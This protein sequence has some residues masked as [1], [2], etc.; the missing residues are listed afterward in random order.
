MIPGLERAE[1]LRCGVMHKNAFIQAPRLLDNHYSM[2]EH[3]DIYFAGQI[4]GVEGYMES[5][6][7]GLLAGLFA[8]CRAL[9]EEPPAFSDATAL[10]ALATHISNK[11][12][13]NFQ[14]MNINY[15]IMRPCGQRIKDKEKKNLS[16]AQRSLEELQC[17]REQLSSLYARTANAQ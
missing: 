6:S 4:T 3:P 15:G 1:F 13:V 10:G 9:G 8:A 12:V 16:I 17:L 14:P 2:R 5:A 7:S 11:S